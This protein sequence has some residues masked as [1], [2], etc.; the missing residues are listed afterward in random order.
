[1]TVQPF[2]EKLINFVELMSTSTIKFFCWWLNCQIC[3]LWTF[4]L[5]YFSL[6]CNHHNLGFY[7]AN[8]TYILDVFQVEYGAP[9]NQ[10][11]HPTNQEN[12][13]TKQTFDLSFHR[14]F[15]R[16][17]RIKII[18]RA[19][20]VFTGTMGILKSSHIDKT[21]ARRTSFFV[22]PLL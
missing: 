4:R 11:N 2:F 5:S 15:Y 14:V 7:I 21:T 18:L 3:D 10:I 22:I 16:F 1:M 8:T 19:V 13:F 6:S 20:D 9:H 17:P 12:W